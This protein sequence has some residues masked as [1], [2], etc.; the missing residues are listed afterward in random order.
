MQEIYVENISKVLTNKEKLEEKL[1]V[2]ITNKGKNVFIDGE[3]HQEYLALE[4]LDAINLNFSVEQALTLQ[5]ENKVLYSLNIK[6]ITKRSGLE[7]I[8]ARIIGTNGKTIKTL[9]KLTACLISLADNQIGIIGNA[10]DIQDSVQA[11]TSLVHGSKQGNVYA[12]LEREKKKKRM[13]PMNY[14]RNK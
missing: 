12:R 8:R 1:E 11:I 2:K 5:E 9:A 14:Q 13:I 10:E 3:P 6:D 4:V 7:R